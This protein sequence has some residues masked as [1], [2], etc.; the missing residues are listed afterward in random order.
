M[1]FFSIL[2]FFSLNCGYNASEIELHSS[3]EE[4]LL[5]IFARQGRK[6]NC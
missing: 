6:M 4:K 1:L 2:H 5:S 3:T